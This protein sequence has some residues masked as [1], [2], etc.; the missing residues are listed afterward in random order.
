M[1]ARSSAL[2]LSAAARRRSLAAAIASVT[3]FGMGIGL[4]APLLSLLLEAR[5]TDAT[6]N[7][8]SA[9]ATFLGVVLGPLLTPRLVRHL[10]IRPLL[11]LCLALDMAIF[12]LMKLYDGVGAWFVLRLGLGLVG[13]SLFTATESWI[14]LLAGDAGRG[15]IIG[16]YAAALSG[17]FALGPLLLSVT[18]TQGW[19]PFLAASAIAA[20]AMLPLLAVG[21]LSRELGREGSGS[22]L[23]ILREAPFIA[24]AA[25]LYGFFESTV[26]SL[27]PVWGVRIGLAGPAAAAMLSSVYLGA[28]ALQLPVGFLSDKLP[29]L[30]VLRLC[31]AAGLVGAVL[32]PLLADQPLPLFLVLFLWGGLAVG[33]YPVAL[34]MAG[35]RYRGAAL[36]TA[37]AAIIVAY[38]MGSLVGP[39]LGGVAMDLWNPQGLLAL[40]ALVFVLFLAA[41]IRARARSVE[42]R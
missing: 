28:I 37:N 9:A 21:D 42:L 34:S 15:R 32:V 4:A 7:G 38:G 24:F 16:L 8:L 20:V 1:S 36:V 10:G 17:G 23:D 22:I 11:L 29:R 26:I 25:G 39:V 33:I 6:V 35:A 30:Q 12:P 40:L 13:S 19:T 14:N 27:L 5:G 31:G 41:A 18:G 2:P 3:V